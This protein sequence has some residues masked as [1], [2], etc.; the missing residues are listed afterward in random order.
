[1]RY[2]LEIAYHGA[3]YHGWQSQ[4]N[5]NTVQAEINKALLTLL[6]T[7]IETIGCGRTD[8]GVHATQFYLHFDFIDT[9]PVDFIYRLNTIL[10]K[11]IAVFNLHIV[12][13]DA[14]ARFDATYRSYIYYIHNHKHPFRN[15]I[16][17]YIPQ[18]IINPV[19]L[20][21]VADCILLYNDF[22]S[23]T[24]TGGQAV[25]HNCT[26]S[27]SHWVI[28]EHILEYHITANRFLRGMVRR[29]V[30]ACIDV[31]KGKISLEEVQSALLHKKILPINTSMP[32]HG[33]FLTKVKYPYL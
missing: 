30:G 14:H 20:K 6:K 25:S 5:V 29:I 28:N 33:L 2:F 22:T 1:M 15:T 7:S 3:A 27:Q 32:P 26:I 17:T 9:L 21:A 10:P 13:D 31:S 11:D 8:T 16:S 4:L 12:H 24:K 23:F 18:H 19:L